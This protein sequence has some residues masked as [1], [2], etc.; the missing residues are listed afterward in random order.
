MILFHKLKQ[1][2][3]QINYTVSSLFYMERAALSSE[4]FSVRYPEN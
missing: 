4:T 2:K 1:I 3:T